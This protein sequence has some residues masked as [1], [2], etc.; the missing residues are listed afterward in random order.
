MINRPMIIGQCK[1]ITRNKAHAAQL[2]VNIGVGPCVISG[3]R[4]P[5]ADENILLG[6]VLQLSVAAVLYTLVQSRSS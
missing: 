6:Q 5:L 1:T 2:P 3:S 4:P